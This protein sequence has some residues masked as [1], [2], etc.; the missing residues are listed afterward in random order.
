M[1]TGKEVRLS[2]VFDPGD[3]RAVVVAADHG[4]MLGPIQGVVDLEKTLRRVVEGKPDAVLLSPG[5]AENAYHLFKGR[6]APA[7][8]VRVD[9]TNTFRD[10]TYTLP[11]RETFFGAVSD[12][13]HALKLGAQAAVTYLFLGYEDEEREAR[14]L[15]LVSEYAAECARVELPLIVEPIPLGPRV[16]K[17]NS[18]E[19]V[20]IAARVAVEAGA[21]ALKVPYTGDPE[22]FSKVVRAA[23]G[24][25]VLVLGGY[26]A[27]SRRDMLEVIVETIE[28]GGSGVVFGRNVVQSQDPASVLKDLRAIV[29][30]GR[31]V[32]EVLA[33]GA[34]PKRAKLEAQPE[35][36]SGCLICVSICS[37]RHEG[38]RDASAGRLR[39]EGAWPGPYELAVCTQCG[40][41]VGACPNGALSANP[42]LGCIDW[43]EAKCDLCGA[44]AE[45][46]PQGVVKLQGSKVKIC[47]LCGGA[48][49]CVDWCPRG[50]LAVVPG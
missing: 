36:C 44:C 40:N 46:C 39:V 4:M 12:P 37:F 14:H 11:V 20:A 22:S 1:G 49:E 48:P 18:A 32:R 16:T 23:A 29:H 6:R 17:A 19:L 31:P 30:E 41:C 26:R 27:L 28:V 25:P 15:S 24:V 50:A 33:G 42:S 38:V 7:L 8:L 47:D 5:Q 2:K 3:G 34:A 9:W 45:A 35:R 43:E 21:D 13:R 10:R